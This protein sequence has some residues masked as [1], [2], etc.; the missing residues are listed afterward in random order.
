MK[1]HRMANSVTV[2]IS[3]AASRIANMLRRLSTILSDRYTKFPV[4][5]RGIN[6]A[7]DYNNRATVDK[8]PK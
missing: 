7:S 5:L 1:Q 8:Y 2:Y 3:Q 4:Q 6:A